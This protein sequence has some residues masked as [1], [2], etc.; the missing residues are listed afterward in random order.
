MFSRGKV[1]ITEFQNE[2]GQEIFNNVAC[3]TS[4]GSDQ[5]VHTRSMIRAFASPLNII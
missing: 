4:K 5:S 2:A 1:P 3:A